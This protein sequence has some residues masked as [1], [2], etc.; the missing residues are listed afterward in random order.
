MA[1]AVAL[2]A[3]LAAA[4][5]A[6]AQDP[7]DR[8]PGVCP[9]GRVEHIFID[10]HSIFDTSDPE[11]DP[12]FRWAYSAA[13]RLHVRTKER[14]IAHELLFRVGDCYEPIL[15]EE[16]ERLLRAYPFISRAD[17]YGIQQPGG[18]YHVVV[19]TED[20]WSTQ[21]EVR[22]DLSGGFELEGLDLR[23]QNL[24]GLGRELGV[25]YRSE[26][27]IRT[28]GARYLTP[29]LLGTRW[30]MSTAVGKT[31]SGTLVE[32]QISYP[33]L[34][35]LG[36]W[37]FRQLLSHQ[38]RHFDYILPGA[39]PA[40]PDDGPDCRVLV[41]IQ[42]RAF[43]VA[44]LWRAGRR[45]NLTVFGGG[46]S[47]QELRYKGEGITLV[48]GGRYD[49]RTPAPTYQR[50]WDKRIIRLSQAGIPTLLLVGNHDLPPNIL[51]ASSIEIYETLAVPNVWIADDYEVQVI[52]TRRGPICTAYSPARWG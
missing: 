18:G 24:A 41:P 17:V 13:N 23:E 26:Q 8:N 44:S 1:S 19:D 12:R 20:E 38:D 15:L 35:E 16:S 49:D 42:D 4:A 10:N 7:D 47:F 32:Q 27:A 43:H 6:R 30:D 33:F 28:Y 3:A 22:A 25:F 9:A 11:L 2:A 5:P 45:G 40:C 21:V 51:R 52:E 34:G 36:G 29:Q 50:E 46:L 48:E 31:R 39:D 37:G 14:V